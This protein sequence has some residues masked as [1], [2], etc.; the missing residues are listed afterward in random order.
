MALSFVNRARMIMDLIR[1]GSVS[2]ESAYSG[3]DLINASVGLK[4]LDAMLEVYGNILPTPPNT[5]IE[6]ELASMSSSEK[7]RLY[8]NF[9]RRFHID[10]LKSSRAPQVGQAASD[11]ESASIESAAPSEIGSKE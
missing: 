11:A 9:L 3:V 8:I 1:D 10:A 7:S 5:T 4:Y 6:E 2:S